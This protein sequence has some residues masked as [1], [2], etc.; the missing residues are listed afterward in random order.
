[1]HLYSSSSMLLMKRMPFSNHPF[2]ILQSAFLNI[3]CTDPYTIVDPRCIRRYIYLSVAK[4]IATGLITSRLDYCNSLLYNIAS[5]D[6]QKLQCVQ[7]CSARV[8]TR[9]IR[10][11]RSVP[12]L[13]SLH[14]F[15]VQSR[16]IFKLCA[17]A[18]QT[19]S[20]GEPSYLFSML[21]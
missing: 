8:L 10:F 1:M 13:I 17:I 9:P 5:K 2:G 16:I 21:L 6:I 19:L 14:W 18:Y 12:L 15:P 3:Y 11:S 4:T 7:N 20:S